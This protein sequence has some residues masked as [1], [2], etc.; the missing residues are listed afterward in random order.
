ATEVTSV[1]E[2]VITKRKVY[3]YVLA[4]D[5]GFAPNPFFGYC[6]LA[7]CKSGIRRKAKEGDW[8][9]GLTPRAKGEGN[10]IVY[11]MEVEKLL[12]FDQY[13]NNSRFRQKRPD[14]DVK[15]GRARRS[16]DNIYE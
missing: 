12:T 16:G 7:C 3:S 4:F 6:T 10:N 14:V 13:W 1:I 2:K 5:A 8:I 9:V 15:A 11:F